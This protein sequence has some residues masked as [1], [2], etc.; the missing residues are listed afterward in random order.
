MIRI[1]C[2]ACGRHGLVPA[3]SGTLENDCESELAV[4][5]PCG[6][7]YIW[8]GAAAELA[9]TWP[10]WLLPLLDAIRRAAGWPGTL[11]AF[12]QGP[13]GPRTPADGLRPVRERAA[14]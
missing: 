11:A 8:R 14:P 6:L 2:P 9:Q 4:C 12:A 13:A 10:A 7:A 1:H 5:P 3:S